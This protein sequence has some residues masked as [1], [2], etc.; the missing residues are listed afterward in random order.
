MPS[1]SPIEDDRSEKIVQ[2]PLLTSDET[3]KQHTPHSSDW[4][5]W[6]VY[7]GHSGWTTSAKLRDSL[8][9][10]VL[11]EL[12]KAY[13]KSTADS[14]NRLVPSPETVDAAIQQGFINLDNDIVHKVSSDSWPILQR[15]VPQNILLQHCL[16]L[17]VFGLLR[18]LFPRS[19]CGCN[20]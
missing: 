13:V 17:A 7:D 5:F 4:M 3:T 8:I 9:A 2:V 14:V 19:S 6:G 20:W 1:N 18:Y 15:Q 16:V 11:A 10:Y 12:D